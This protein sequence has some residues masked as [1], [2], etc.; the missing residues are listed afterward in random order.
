MTHAKGDEG[1]GAESDGEDDLD[2]DV[3]GAF[4]ADEFVPVSIVPGTVAVV[5]DCEDMA[6]CSCRI[7]VGA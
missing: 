2:R 3:A 1:G 5:H 6:A 7:V 4:G